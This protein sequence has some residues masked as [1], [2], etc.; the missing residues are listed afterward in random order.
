MFREQVS[1][2]VEVTFLLVF[3]VWCLDFTCGFHAGNTKGNM[4]MLIEY[5]VHYYFLNFLINNLCPLNFLS[6]SLSFV[7]LATS[8]LEVIWKCEA[9]TP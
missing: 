3:L 2:D 8:A 9:T 7:L 4:L 6:F 5:I 1:D